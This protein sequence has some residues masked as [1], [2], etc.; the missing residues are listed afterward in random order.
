MIS[1][2]SRQDARLGD[3]RHVLPCVNTDMRVVTPAIRNVRGGQA[4]DNGCVA[5]R[6]SFHN[7]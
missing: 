6:L 4:N 3:W 2:R 7:V 5:N 1:I